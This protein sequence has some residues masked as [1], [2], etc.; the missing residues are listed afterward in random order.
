MTIQTN[1]RRMAGILQAIKPIKL[2]SGTDFEKG[3]G[4]PS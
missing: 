1:L 3:I 4:D 2:E